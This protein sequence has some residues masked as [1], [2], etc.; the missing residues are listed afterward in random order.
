VVGIPNREA[1]V[2]RAGLYTSVAVNRH[3]EVLATLLPVLVSPDSIGLIG[4]D[5]GQLGIRMRY[6]TDETRPDPRE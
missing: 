5:F 6:A 4:A 2:V 1:V 3:L